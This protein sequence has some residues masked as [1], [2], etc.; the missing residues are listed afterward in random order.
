MTFVIIA[1]SLNVAAFLSET[2]RSGIMSVNKGEIEA[3]YSVGMTTFKVFKRIILPQALVTSI[4]NFCNTSIG[5]LHGTALAFYISVIE[6]TGEANIS[7]E[8]NWKYFEAYVAA[9]IIYWGVSIVFEQVARGLEHYATR[10]L[11]TSN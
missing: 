11:R 8:N 5:L 4:P 1:F 2:I 3:A 10:H 6:M 7:A 9:A